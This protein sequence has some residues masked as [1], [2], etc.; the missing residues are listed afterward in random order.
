M[1]L[2]LEPLP[3]EEPAAATDLQDLEPGPE[4]ET[5]ANE[6]VEAPIHANFK[7]EQVGRNILFVDDDYN[8]L[9]LCKR[10]FGAGEYTIHVANGPTEALELLANQ[11]IDIII[12]DMSMPGMTGAEL[13]H[14]VECKHP[15]I[16]RIII[17]GKFD[18]ADTIAAIN[19]GHIYQYLTK[20]FNDKDV[21]LTIY[22]ALLE[23]ERR[24]AEV[25]RQ[26][27][28]QENARRRARQMGQEVVKTKSKLD[29]AYNE[30]I[31]LL[32]RLVSQGSD[33]TQRIA[34]VAAWLAVQMNENSDAVH[35]VRVAALLQ[36][37]SRLG[38][39]EV[40]VA[41]MSSEQKVAYSRHPQE[42]ARLV[43]ELGPFQEA[44]FIV[45]CHH[46]RYDG[47]GFPCKLK[48]V[49]IPLGAR[50]V[51]LAN[52]YGK[53]RAD[54]SVSHIE[55]IE[56]LAGTGERFDPQLREQLA[57]MPASVYED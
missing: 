44:S 20:P 13:L 1:N 17:S 57:L 42:S 31:S 33:Q 30:C 22:K 37:L 14:V 4:V 36:D 24:E 28:R 49:E 25:R 50:A 34:N 48:G 45:K 55:A 23:K 39:P 8:F 7:H 27:E 18:L 6:F 40:P 16:I 32:T 19:K 15:D 35:Q 12:S 47:K 11:N 46:E 10:R 51:A 21:K 26:Q 3:G 43:A 54:Y 29:E 52:A 56:T 38:Q 5:Q 53:L 2:S 41:G 9:E